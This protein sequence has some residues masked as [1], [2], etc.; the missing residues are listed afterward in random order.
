MSSLIQDHELWGNV[1]TGIA[2]FITVSL[3]VAGMI[4][5]VLPF[6]PGH[7]ILLMAAISHHLM[8]GEDSGL[9]WWSFLILGGLMAASQTLEM[10]SGAAGS[11][12][13]GGSKW[14]ALGALAGAL[15]GLL[16]LPIGLLAGPLLGAFVF[17]T[18]FAKKEP[19]TAA[20]SGLGSVV[21]TVAGLGV[22]IVAG[23]LMVGWFVLDVALQ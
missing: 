9:Q 1:G 11:R 12:W 14:G 4:G 10:V 3:L 6:L 23:V 13:F 19:K 5:C 15:G 2:W 8:L 18:A 7:L 16:F 21:G 20:V 17:E 22:K